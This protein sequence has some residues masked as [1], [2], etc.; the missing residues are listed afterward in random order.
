MF[1]APAARFYLLVG[2]LARLGEGMQ[3][4]PAPK[5][6]KQARFLYYR[7]RACFS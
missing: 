4:N 3:L 2:D 5:L 1:S 7:K 6:K